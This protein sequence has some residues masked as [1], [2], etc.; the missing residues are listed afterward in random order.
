MIRTLFGYILSGIGVFVLGILT[1]FV[2][3]NA[4]VEDTT[5][6]ITALASMLCL[7]LGVAI[8]GRYTQRR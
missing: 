6:T 1:A 3:V 2:A 7:F 4:R 5:F 8:M